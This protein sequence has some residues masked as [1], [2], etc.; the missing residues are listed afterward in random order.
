M[1]AQTLAA[2]ESAIRNHFLAGMDD[3][4]RDVRRNAVVIDWVA[5]FTISNIVDVDGRQM[6]GF[7]NEYVSP[8]TNP[9]SQAH[10][11]QWAADE[12]SDILRP[13]GDD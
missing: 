10:L 12:I 7:H 8:D 1:S 5:A 2:V 3:D 11:A 9:N 4:T 13:G 6:V